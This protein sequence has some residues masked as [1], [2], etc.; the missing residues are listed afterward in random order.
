M[1]TPTY[2][3]IRRLIDE[4]RKETKVKARRELGSALYN[5][6]KNE[7]VLRKL[8]VEATPSKS[9]WPDEDSIV[10]KRYRA[11][12]LVWSSAIQGAIHVTQ[13]IING[14]KVKLTEEDI[15]LPYNLLLASDK[16]N[17]IL[18]DPSVAIPILP[19][20]MVRS[21]LKYCLELLSDDNITIGRLKLLEMLS[22][23]CSKPDHVGVF[24]H[25]HDVANILGELFTYLT[26]DVE[27]KNV[28]LFIEAAKA[29]DFLI[30]SAKVLGIEIH[31]FVDS[32]ISTIAAF[33]KVYL[34]GHNKPIRHQA[35]SLPP[36]YN[37]IANILYMHPDHAI[38]PIKRHGRTL[39]RHAKKCYANAK[40]PCKEALNSYIAAHL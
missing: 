30:S 8:A 40:S 38:G 18:G 36:L 20:K 39:L 27:D 13:S 29:L 14:K 31:I 9:N 21:L 32:T 16:A 34:V 22:F 4:L 1:A 28:E 37:T 11:I 24:K 17:E 12:S 19:K 35:P 5:K 23:L 3:E 26:G 33:F 10:A 7:N 25:H 2:N 15:A 6:L